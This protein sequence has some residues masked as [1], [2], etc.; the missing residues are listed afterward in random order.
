MTNITICGS[1]KFGTEMMSWKKRL[2]DEGFNVFVPGETLDLTNYNFPKETKE[3]TQRKI[4]HD[5]INAHFRLIKKSEGILVLNYDKNGVKNYIG[6]NS[7]MELG[8]AFSLNRDIFMLNSSPE[9]SYQAEVDAMQPI[10]IRGK[11][12]TIKNYYQKLPSVYLSSENILKLSAVSLALREFNFRYNTVG[13]KTKSSVRDQPSSIEETYQG[14]ENRLKDLKTK[15]KGKEYKLLISI[16]SGISSLHPK[17]SNWGFSVCIIETEKGKRV[18]TINSELE[19]PK[20]MT[21]LVPSKYPDLGILMQQKYGAK[22]K[23]PYLH[24]TG[25]KLSREKLLFNSVV[26]TLATL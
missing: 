15:T 6:G 2:T 16:E 19:V 14:A 1:M 22:N 21:D 13:I 10:I 17:H 23:D 5:Y 8:Y 26:N 20:E 7:L 11:L 3:A 24:L 25:G 12:S 4:S 18:V 9:M